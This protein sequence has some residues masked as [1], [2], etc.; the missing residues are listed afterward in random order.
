MGPR[1]IR[2]AAIL[3]AFLL[4]ALLSARVPAHAIG[5]HF[6]PANISV[7]ARPGQVVNST[8]SLTL[9]KDSPATR[10]R[11]R[12][13]D[14]WRS[15]DNSKTFYAVPGTI[16]RSCGPWCS[17]NPVESAVQPGGTMTVRLSVRVPD[18]VEPGGYWSALTL[19]EIPDPLAPKPTGVA[20]IFRGSVSVG[21]LVEIPNAV[22]AGQITGVRVTSDKVAVTLRND[23]NIPLRINGK[24]EFRKP[25]EQKPTATVEIGGEPLL[26]EPANTCEFSAALPAAKTLPSGRYRVRVTV[27]AGL[28]YLMGAEKELDLN[29]TADAGGR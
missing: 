2:R 27:D 17:V 10:F 13:E 24:F 20:V 3:G 29:R 8:F 25:G 14:W 4:F 26:P 11:A 6:S 5:F 1:R 23:G 21:I 16:K 7:Q 18:K 22:R 28:D 12:I 19:E 9:A 15:S